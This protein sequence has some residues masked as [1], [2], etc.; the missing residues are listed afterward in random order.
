MQ[1]GSQVTHMSISNTVIA[2]RFCTTRSIMER[3]EL[4][5]FYF[6]VAR[7][8]MHL[9]LWGKPVCITQHS[10]NRTELLPRYGS[11]GNARCEYGF[12]PIHN[13][14]LWHAD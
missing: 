10:V 7:M 12:Y 11:I 5:S 8:A 4:L 9:T 1:P 3:L 2:R 13:Q 14:F 6:L